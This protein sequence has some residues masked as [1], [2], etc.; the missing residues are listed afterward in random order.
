MGH[1]SI[2]EPAVLLVFAGVLLFAML[3][4][5]VAGRVG[6]PGIIAFV[7]IGLGL[8]ATYTAAG[9]MPESVILLIDI[10]AKV[11]VVVLLFQAGMHTDVTRLLGQI[12][13]V[14]IIWAMNV[15]VAGGF[16]L[17]AAR[18]ILGMQLIPSIVIAVALTAT[19]VG[20][21]V[22]VWEEHKREDTRDGRYF[23]GVAGLDDISAVVLM[24]ILFAVAPI[25]RGEAD[26]DIATVILSRL[27]W[28]LV[29]LVGFGALCL[30][31][32]RY[33]E[34]R[35]RAALQRFESPAAALVSVVAVS[36]IISAC[37]GLLGFSVAIGAF[38]AGLAFSGDPE[39]LRAHIAFDAIYDI[40]VPF[41]FIGIGVFID[42]ATAGAAIIPGLVLLAAAVAGKLVANGGT[43]LA[44]AS[45][46]GAAAIGVSMVPRA[47]IT[48]IIMQKAHSLGDW[49]APQSALA[50]MV[51]VSLITTIVGPPALDA[52]LRR[53]D[54]K[55]SK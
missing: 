8:N 28:T 3:G 19:S 53:I 13:P 5:A 30:L 38:L 42:L 32:S 15:V 37:A 20:L 18:A 21:A 16:G 46:L 2:N 40:L 51:F 33:V 4:R 26:G 27:G 10:L 35:L 31:F 1:T 14:A 22:A 9:G 54:R 17:V 55:A 45:P 41:F 39:A 25:L 48:M 6:L 52:V 12:G 23:L 34:H 7:L 49:A 44:Y 47:E 43:A 36:I 29:K 50:A 11:G 24:A